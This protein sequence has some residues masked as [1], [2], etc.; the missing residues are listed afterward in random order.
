MEEVI[1]IN[2]NTKG[3]VASLCGYSAFPK[4][5]PKEGQ[6]IAFSN[7]SLPLNLVSQ[8]VAVTIVQIV[9]G[10]AP[11]KEL[12]LLHFSNLIL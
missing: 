2:C 6:A 4:L 7:T 10:I 1:C 3:H 5:Q 9:H 11:T 12:L 8:M